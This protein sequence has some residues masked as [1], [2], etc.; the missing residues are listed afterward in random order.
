[1]AGRGDRA[2]CGAAVEPVGVG[3]LLLCGFLFA[4]AWHHGVGECNATT[5]E[6]GATGLLRAALV[7]A[8]A[9]F[10]LC[11]AAWRLRAANSQPWTL[12]IGLACAAIGT[13]A[14]ALLVGVNFRGC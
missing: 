14:L 12:L 3:A 10:G 1:V 9:D 6:N 7:I 2:E 8:I 4:L 13:V 5:A 11:V